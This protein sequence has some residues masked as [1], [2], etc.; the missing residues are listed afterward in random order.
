MAFASVNANTYSRKSYSRCV[1]IE[2]ILKLINFNATYMYR[3]NLISYRSYLASMDENQLNI[4]YQGH[5]GTQLGPASQKRRSGF[6][7]S[8]CIWNTSF[9]V[10]CTITS[11]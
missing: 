7:A 3:L 11:F 4:S 10:H 5:L 8:F 6:I 2:D 1:K 9:L